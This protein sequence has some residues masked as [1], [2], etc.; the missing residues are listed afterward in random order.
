M[1]D[2]SLS[3]DNL[4][5]EFAKEHPRTAAHLSLA[6]SQRCANLHRYLQGVRL[7]GFEQLLEHLDVV[8]KVYSASETLQKVAF[9][10]KRSVGD[11]VTALDAAMS[12]NHNVAHDAMRDVMEIEFLL[13]DFSLDVSRINVW[14]TA[15]NDNLYKRFRPAVLRQRFATHLGV[16]VNELSEATD[17][18][19]HSM[20]LHVGPRQNPFGM[21]GI[22]E[23]IDL[24]AVDSCFWEIFEHA[25][26]LLIAIDTLGQRV[27]A[28]I[29]ATHNPEKLDK[30]GNAWERTQ[31]MQQIWQQLIQKAV[32]DKKK[33]T[34]A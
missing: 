34:D 32:S 20:F 26:R 1:N 9:L 25:R 33:K 22:A 12:G 24:F 15:N 29:M 28:G 16:Q 8:H 13:R 5:D 11:F 18:K 30:L 17:Y 14:L 27:E 23:Q 4:L 7:G 3:Y 6:S 31:E 10:V 19:G 21:P 2:K